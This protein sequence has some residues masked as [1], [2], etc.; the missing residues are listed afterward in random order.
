LDERRAA[1][2]PF[3]GPS[4]ATAPL[5]VTFDRSAY[6]EVVGHA[7]QSLEFEI[8]GVLAGE[9]F[10]DDR[11]PFV[12]VQAAIRGASARE[13]T[14]HVTY[15]QE[16]WTAIHQELDA[17]YPKLAIVGWYHSH[18]GFGVQ[19]S[20]MDLFIQRN[21]FSAP[22]QIGLVSDPLGGEEAVYY[23]APEGVEPLDRFWVEGRQRICRRQVPAADVTGESPATPPELI[24]TLARLDARLTQLLQAAD[25]Q[26]AGHARFLQTVALMV[27]LA[28]AVWIGLNIYQAFKATFEPPELVTHATMPL[29]VGDKT[30][31]LGLGV[32]EWNVPP[33]I[34]AAYVALEEKRR[35]AEAAAAKER[36]AAAAKE[37][38]ADEKKGSDPAEKQRGGGAGKQPA[39]DNAKGKPH[40]G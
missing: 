33:E 15:T 18:P 8:C 20:E 29:R 25:Q 35:A 22:T 2:R 5:R 11:G 24:D 23:N 3:P 40:D 6:A 19:F 27:G 26:Q 7:K 14:T 10:Q 1:W 32:V 38:A 17:K 12:H 4:S 37:S 36:A 9:I 21:F 34:T 30:V 16:T 28:L 13:G 39:Q 31:M